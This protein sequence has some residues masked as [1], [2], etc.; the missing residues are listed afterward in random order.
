M[1]TIYTRSTVNILLIITEYI[2]TVG[3]HISVVQYIDPWLITH[4]KQSCLLVPPIRGPPFGVSPL[5]TSGRH[6]LVGCLTTTIVKT[7]VFC[8]DQVFFLISMA[9]KD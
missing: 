2:F 1:V 5:H 7:Y 3:G 6:G 4:C 8:S 9:R